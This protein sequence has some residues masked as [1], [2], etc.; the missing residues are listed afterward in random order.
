MTES[1]ANICQVHVLL[2]SKD[3][4]SFPLTLIMRRGVDYALKFSDDLISFTE[5][6]VDIEGAGIIKHSLT[7]ATFRMPSLIGLNCKQRQILLLVKNCV[8]S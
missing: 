1:E 7:Q 2:L 4:S 3:H 8:F 6:L 5:F